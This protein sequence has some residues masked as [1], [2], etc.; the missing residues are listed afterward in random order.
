MHA[1]VVKF[2]YNCYVNSVGKCIHSFK[3]SDHNSAIYASPL[4]MLVKKR[5]Y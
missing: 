1:I 5:I 4:A 3:F 2:L